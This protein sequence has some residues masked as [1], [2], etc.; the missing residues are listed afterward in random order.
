MHSFSELI[1]EGYNFVINCTGFGAKWLCNDNKLVPLRG[2]VY[3]VKAPWIKMFYY[4]D[5]DTVFLK[6]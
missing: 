6:Y 5:Y 3:K 1:D 2:Q 4:G